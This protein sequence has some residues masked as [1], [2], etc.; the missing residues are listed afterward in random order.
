MAPLE[1]RD[2]FLQA[3]RRLVEGYEDLDAVARE[4]LRLDL[5]FLPAPVSVAE[6]GQL[7]LLE[8]TL[9]TWDVTVGA[10][11]GATLAAQAVPLLLDAVLRLLG[12]IAK[13]EALGPVRAHLAVELTD[14]PRSYGLL[15]GDRVSVGEPPDQPDGVLRLPAE[16]L[17]RLLT[18]RLAP[19]HTP[20]GVEA[21]GPVALD[22]LRRVFPGF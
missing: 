11:P 17:L 19:E 10:D 12:W 14:L 5:G 2:G 4:E 9:H 22:D 16:A 13:P 7:R 21:S 3:N 15:L 18:G 1:R 8:F 6:A 20:A